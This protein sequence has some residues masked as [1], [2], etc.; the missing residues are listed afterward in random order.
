MIILILGGYTMII[1]FLA[2]LVNNFITQ[3]YSMNIKYYQVMLGL[4]I[5]NFIVYIFY[6][7]IM[8]MKRGI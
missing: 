5:F 1:N 2:S 7:I 3:L 6:K 4:L 8:Q